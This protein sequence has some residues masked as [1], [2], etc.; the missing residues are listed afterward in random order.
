MPSVANAVFDDDDRLLLLRH[1]HSGLWGMPGGAM[2]PGE[3]PAS[4]ATRELS[5]ETGLAC[6]PY[7]LIG[8]TGGPDHI[9]RYPNGDR[10]AYVTT[11]FAVRWDGTEVQPDGT[12]V[13]EALWVSGDDVGKIETDVLTR[14]NI[15][16]I[17]DWYAATPGDQRAWFR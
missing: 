6:E 13:D 16:L 17:F 11:I 2:E 15:Q 10:T 14:E 7:A 9:V 4:A 3:T 5:E 1:L 12:E 8:V